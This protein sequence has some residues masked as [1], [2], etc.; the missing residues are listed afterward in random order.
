MRARL[1]RWVLLPVVAVLL[2]AVQ[3][4]GVAA[5]DSSWQPAVPMIEA[6]EQHTATVLADGR[7]LVVGG[8]HNGG[9]ATAELYD[10]RTRE[11][12]Y[13][14]SLA[15]KRGGQPAVLLEDGRVLVVGVTTDF[16]EDFA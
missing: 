4:A 1:I 9:S 6:R 2:A 15:S 10:P 7:V 14:G 16:A 13:T 5:Q 3:I 8:S 12:T 11:W